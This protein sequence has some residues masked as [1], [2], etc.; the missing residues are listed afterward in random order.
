MEKMSLTVVSET[1]SGKFVTQVA[2]LGDFRIELLKSKSAPATA[3]FLPA[4]VSRDNI[5]YWGF[6][7][8]HEGYRGFA[9]LEEYG[10]E[11]I[12]VLCT[13]TN[14]DM[15]IPLTNIADI[16]WTDAGD[17]IGG[18]KI[19]S[20]IKMKEFLAEKLG[21]EPMWSA[22]E[23]KMLQAIRNIAIAERTAME[24]AAKLA[25]EKLAADRKRLQ[26][27]VRSK[28]LMR[29][30]VYGFTSTGDPRNGVPVVG[31][32]WE[33]LSGDTF[34]IS[35]D[36]WN[37][38]TGEAGALI[39]SFVI[40]KNGAKKDRKA[41]VAVTRDNPQQRQTKPALSSLS[42]KCISIKGEVEEV[43]IAPDMAT[44]HALNNGGLNSGTLVMCP[45]KDDADAHEVFKLMNGKIISVT[46]LR[47]RRVA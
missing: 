40:V 39:E 19:Q 15:V 25:A 14:L 11:L 7:S 32:E 35:V 3:V 28:I 2:T 45:K 33:M 22:R 46:T 13:K 47:R 36:S 5:R 44:V 34:C 4:S 29:K 21:L 30:R 1:D 41:I 16:T 42:S 26:N 27:E 38:N 20:L 12:I 17:Y 43:F 23:T 31:N 18:R 10:E 24:M 8:H 37:D 9:K 6:K